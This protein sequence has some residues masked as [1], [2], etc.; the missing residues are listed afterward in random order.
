MPNLVEVGQPD[1]SVLKYIEGYFE[2]YDYY[3]AEVECAMDFVGSDQNKTFH[4]LKRTYS[5]SWRGQGFNP[6]YDSTE[7]GNNIRRARFKGLRLYTKEVAAGKSA[8]VE[9]VFKHDPKKKDNLLAPKKIADVINLKSR[10][11]SKYLRFKTVNPERIIS[12]YNKRR[13]KDPERY[14]VKTVELI[15]NINSKINNENIRAAADYAK[16][17]INIYYCFEAHPFEAI[18]YKNLNGKSFVNRDIFTV[19]G[20][21]L[22]L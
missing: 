11:I 2:P 16:G 7:Y 9:M 22:F 5:L 14:D 13:K 4:A 17:Y 15:N 3:V 19:N 21:C 12:S 8:R 18:F 20:D 1:L 10:L 6:D